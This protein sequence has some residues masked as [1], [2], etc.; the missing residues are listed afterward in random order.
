MMSL[1]SERMPLYK[2]YCLQKLSCYFLLDCN[3]FDIADD[4]LATL[5]Q[6]VGSWQCASTITMVDSSGIV[7]TM[8]VTGVCL[9]FWLPWCCQHIKGSKPFLSQSPIVVG[10][11]MVGEKIFCCYKGFNWI[12]CNI[13][14][15]SSIK[16]LWH[17][18]T[19]WL[20]PLSIFML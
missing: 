5:S 17:Y 9:S 6:Q 16:K 18:L 13:K 2:K 1:L 4:M 14:T 15:L 7:L 11:S 10:G 20:M 12:I 8:M 19:K 3:V